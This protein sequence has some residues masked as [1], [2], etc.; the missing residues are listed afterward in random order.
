MCTARVYHGR[1]INSKQHQRLISFRRDNSRPSR[2]PAFCI[3]AKYPYTDVQKKR[4]VRDG[5]F[6]FKEQ[7]KKHRQPPPHDSSHDPHSS[8]HIYAREQL[9]THPTPGTPTTLVRQSPPIQIPPPLMYINR[10]A[11]ALPTCGV[12]T[13]YSLARASL[14]TEHPVPMRHA[15]SYDACR[16]YR[17]L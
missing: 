6:M 1:I 7:K 13:T 3:R 10:R 2:L 17:R 4:D 9:G 16:H 15:H 8:Y 11:A 14:R 5:A 12:N